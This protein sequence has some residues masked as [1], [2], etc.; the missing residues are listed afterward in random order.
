MISISVQASYEHDTILSCPNL[1]SAANPSP[2]A[3]E[4]E[5]ITVS[6]KDEIVLMIK[7]GSMHNEH[8]T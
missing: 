2:D 5:R 8:G 4:M 7:I 6:W 1:E 3:R